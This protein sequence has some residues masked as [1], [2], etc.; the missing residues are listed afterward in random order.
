MRDDQEELD[1]ESPHGTTEFAATSIILSRLLVHAQIYH[2][3]LVL[4]TSIIIQ[5]SMDLSCSCI[6][7]LYPANTVR[8]P[9]LQTIIHHFAGL[10]HRIP[11][12]SRP[13]SL[14]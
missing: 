8:I 3:V 14:F 4:Y 1:Y 2:G 5:E 7:D 11:T 10:L 13:S 6:C 12:E 9:A